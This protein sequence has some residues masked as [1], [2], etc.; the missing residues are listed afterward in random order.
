MKNLTHNGAPRMVLT[1]FKT[2]SVAIFCIFAAIHPEAEATT[3]SYKV[4]ALGLRVADQDPR[5]A[6]DIVLSASTSNY[7][8]FQAAGL[9]LVQPESRL[10]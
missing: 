6:K 2:L 9:R 1:A 5:P 3:Y 4:A 7:N 8:L 10:P